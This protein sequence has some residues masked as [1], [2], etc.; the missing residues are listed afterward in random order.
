MEAPATLRDLVGYLTSLDVAFVTAR[1]HHGTQLHDARSGQL[2][3]GAEYTDEANSLISR[4]P[5]RVARSA[6][7]MTPTTC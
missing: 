7:L 5:R 4:A 6:S 1:H 2:F 3:G